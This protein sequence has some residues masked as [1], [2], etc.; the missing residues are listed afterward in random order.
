MSNYPNSNINFISTN[1][2]TMS[3][4]PNSNINF[5]STNSNAFHGTE[6]NYHAPTQ[7]G[8]INRAQSHVENLDSLIH[9]VSFAGDFRLNCG[10]AIDLKLAPS[11][12]PQVKV[13][14]GESQGT[15]VQD[16][17]FSGKYV[18]TSV[19][20]K[21]AEDYTVNAKLKKD[22]LPFSFKTIL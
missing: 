22:S 12:D 1:S 16:K 14:T 7:N 13:K 6:R 21:F 20:H 5:I 10:I 11:I 17:F 15:P 2:D 19:V 8:A 4:Y 18:V 3:N 9:D